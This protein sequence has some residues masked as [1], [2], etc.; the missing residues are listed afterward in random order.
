[1]VKQFEGVVIKTG[2]MIKYGFIYDIFLK[3]TRKRQA[4]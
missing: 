2:L 1:M 4:C 3:H